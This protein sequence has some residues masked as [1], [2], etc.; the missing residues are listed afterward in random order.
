MAAR[1]CE[2]PAVAGAACGLA[3]RERYSM[4]T[5][6]ARSRWSLISAP[7]SAP[8]FDVRA[9]GGKLCCRGF[10]VVSSASAVKSL[11]GRRFV[12][13]LR[14]AEERSEEAESSPG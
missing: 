2:R 3:R 11:A 13:G 1:A 12:D 5:R 7:T 6:K 10:N 9:R 14:E 4:P 8:D